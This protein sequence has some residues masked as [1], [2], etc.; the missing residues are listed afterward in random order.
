MVCTGGPSV[1]PVVADSDSLVGLG[2]LTR[3]QRFVSE[4]KRTFGSVVSSAG[5]WLPLRCRFI[6]DNAKS[7]PIRPPAAVRDA[8]STEVVIV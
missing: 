5:C 4:Q 6:Q 2:S 1:D 8:S 7:L 3:S